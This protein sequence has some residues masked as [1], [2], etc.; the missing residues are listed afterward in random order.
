MKLTSLKVEAVS[1]ISQNQDQL[2]KISKDATVSP[3]IEIE[4]AMLAKVLVLLLE[5]VSFP[6]A[7]TF[8][9]S[10]VK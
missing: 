2:L 10:L 8:H 4:N 1:L 3:Q 5:V 6:I 9:G 7:H